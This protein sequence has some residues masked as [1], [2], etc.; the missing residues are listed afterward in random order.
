MKY[1]GTVPI[2]LLIT[3]ILLSS[4]V[5]SR[6]VKK[7]RS[8]NTDTLVLAHVL[9]RHGDR[10]P[11]TAGLWNSNPYYNESYYKPYGYAQLTNDGKR[12]M[13]N[14]G[15][16]L[17]KRYDEFLGK[18]WEIG[19][20]DAWSTN[21]NRT[22]MS[23]SLVL[24]GLYPP[25]SCL[26]W[27]K[28]LA[29]QPIPYNYL[30][31]PD[32]RELSSWACPTVVPLI[33]NT[34]STAERLSAYDGLIKTLS[35]GTGRDLDYIDALDLYFGMLIQSQL[36]FPLQNWTEA[37]YPE[38]LKTYIIDFYYIET[39][40]QA[41]KKVIAG[42]LVKKI[43]SDTQKK[44][45]GT[46][47]PENRKLFLYSAHE[48]NLGTVIAALELTNLTEIPGYGSYLTFEVHNIDNVYGI[49]IFFQNYESEDP[50]LLTLPGCQEFCPFDDFVNLT[51]DI[52]PLSDSE[53]TG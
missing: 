45:N 38:P 40:T 43:I 8:Y 32:D 6:T 17:R 21:Y 22:K 15:L 41:L 47:T 1:S 30:P 16:E 13:Y 3:I 14:V 12:R 44:I 36:G 35:E 2:I 26:I 37:I 19:V 50:I 29:W 7:T 31:V 24:A 48:T 52:I 25:N 39:S 20:L 23:T 11:S 10:T 34:S 27:K 53:C 4:K 9:F 5:S 51:A 28:D 42:Y 46:L 18:T 33:Y 49:K